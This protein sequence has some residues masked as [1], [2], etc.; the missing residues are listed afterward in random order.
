MKVSWKLQL[1]PRSLKKETQLLVRPCEYFGGVPVHHLTTEQLQSLRGE[2]SKS[3]GPAFINMEM[4][5]GRRILK[6][7]KGGM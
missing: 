4:G 1:A 6:R 7:A 3:A 5:V 2:R